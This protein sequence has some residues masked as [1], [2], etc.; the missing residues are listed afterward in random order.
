MSL[1]KFKNQKL[2]LSKK[3]Y[4]MGILNIT[5]DS[6]SD[7]GKFNTYEKILNRAIE[8]QKE[9]AD[10][11]DIGAQS[12]R[13]GFIKISAKDEWERLRPFLPDIR[14]NIKIPISI[15]TFYPEV[16]EKSLSF[17][18]D[19]INDVSGTE[20]LEMIKVIKKSKC[21]IIVTHCYDNLNIR[22]FFENKLNALT[23]QGINPESICFDPGIGFEK[24]RLQDAYI[25]NNISKIKIQNFP[26]L[27]GLSR[28]RII[29]E[30]CKCEK[31]DLE[32]LMSGTLA[33]N[34]ISIM[35]GANIIRVHDVKK[36][37]YAA[38]M[39]D[40]LLNQTE[41]KEKAYECHNN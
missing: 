23:K 36:C 7:G 14:K 20:S 15:D 6:F 1:F 26:L 12:T 8:I 19:I 5:P 41:K 30:A 33:A 9:G 2:D 25:I 32:A 38:K 4:V 40:Y 11:L 37:V 17:G 35:G 21:G 31:T 29:S 27:I 16:A 18:A 22:S 3:T 28:K 10:I 13:P 24:N 34:T 39:A